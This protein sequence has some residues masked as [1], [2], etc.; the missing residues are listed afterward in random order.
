MLKN[1]RSRK[2]IIPPHFAER[3][4][5]Q[6]FARFMAD[7]NGGVLNKH[8]NHFHKL[9]QPCV[10]KYDAIANM[11]TIER[12]ANDFLATL[13][14]EQNIKLNKPTSLWETIKLQL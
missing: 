2:S 10:I 1:Y 12:D 13:G 4:T 3:P 6:E 14:L 9:C 11:E 7:S 8:W 5:W